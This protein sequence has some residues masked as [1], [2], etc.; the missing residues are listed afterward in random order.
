MSNCPDPL[1]QKNTQ[2]VA[3]WDIDHLFTHARFCFVGPRSKTQ[4][5]HDREWSEET[6]REQGGWEVV[7][8]APRVIIVAVIDQDIG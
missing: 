7:G 2:V 5:Y 8:D 1:L 6:G 4:H 3:T